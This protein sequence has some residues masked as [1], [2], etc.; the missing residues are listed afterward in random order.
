MTALIRKKILAC[1][2]QWIFWTLQPIV[3]CGIQSEF[4]LNHDTKMNSL[5]KKQGYRVESENHCFKIHVQTLPRIQREATTIE[6]QFELCW[7]RSFLFNTSNSAICASGAPCP[8]R[9][10]CKYRI[11]FH[12]LYL[13][14]FKKYD[15]SQ[16]ECILTHVTQSVQRKR[17]KRENRRKWTNYTTNWISREPGWD[18]CTHTGSQGTKVR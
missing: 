9:T 11:T 10:D 17:P 8:L 18:N 15:L 4:V 16:G 14:H 7:W 6:Q 2:F 5:E 13:K 1:I 12:F 3:V